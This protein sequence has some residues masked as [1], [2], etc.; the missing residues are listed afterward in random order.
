MNELDKVIFINL[1]EVNKAITIKQI[2]KNINRKE[3]SEQKVAYRIRR[4]SEWGFLTKIGQRNASIRLSG[5]G[6]GYAKGLK[7][8]NEEKNEN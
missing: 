7:M 1:S 3:Y 6:S 8:L 5:L 2:T 4:L